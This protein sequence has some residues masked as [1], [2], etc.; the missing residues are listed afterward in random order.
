MKAMSGKTELTKKEILMF[1]SNIKKL[2]KDNTFFRKVLYTGKQ[3]QLV[4]MSLKPGE[5][6]GEETHDKID[7][8]F[9]FV[10]GDGESV[11]EGKAR[12]FREHEAVF[13]PAGTRHNIKNTGKEPLQ[14]FTI[15][16]PPAHPDGTI[17]KLKADAL[18]AEVIH[19]E[20]LVP[21]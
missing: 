7:Q 18:K 16:A 3:S 1:Q 8:I 5:D 4:L 6:I 9:Y 17:H 14:L 11:I 2:A 19:Q 21:M 15:Y 10:E 13:V 12:P 20:K